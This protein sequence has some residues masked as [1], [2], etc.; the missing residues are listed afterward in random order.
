VR[1]G[2][3]VVVHTTGSPATVRAL[4]EAGAAR[5][6]QLVD[7]PVSGAAEDIGEGHI[8]VM[9]GGDAGALAVARDLVSAYGDPVI[10]LGPLG[11]AQ[12]VKLLNNALLA[13]QIQLA[14]EVERIAAGY[15]IDGPAVAAA[16]Q[17]SSGA[18]YAMSLLADMGSTATIA[19]RAGHFLHKDVAAVFEVAA[20]LGLDLGVLGDVNRHG[21]VTFAGRE[22]A[23]STADT[24]RAEN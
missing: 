8:T 22:V 3:V 7:A 9:L 14:G 5:G 21:P 24:G 10:E 2:A 19:E 12:L 16:I 11:S 4:A 17:Q 13:A 23:S 6:V 18:S 20:E 1:P 15:G